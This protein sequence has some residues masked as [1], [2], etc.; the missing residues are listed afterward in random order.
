MGPKSGVRTERPHQIVFFRPRNRDRLPKSD[1]VSR[2]FREVEIIHPGGE[3]LLLPS[4]LYRS[5]RFRVLEVRESKAAG[6]NRLTKRP[7]FENK[8][9]RRT[10]FFRV[11]RKYAVFWLRKSRFRRRKS[12]KKVGFWSNF[13]F[14]LFSSKICK[15]TLKSR[16]PGSPDIA[17]KSI[18]SWI[19]TSFWTSPGPGFGPIFG[20]ISRPGHLRPYLLARISRRELATHLPWTLSRHGSQDPAQLA[21]H[22]SFESRS[23]R[24]R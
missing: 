20:Q 8:H 9:L 16:I 2:P 13:T 15:K 21:G 12:T 4:D 7:F 6:P 17:E 23:A 5:S 1:S 19:W 24:H 18:F 11:F 14:S 22:C 3:R 10:P